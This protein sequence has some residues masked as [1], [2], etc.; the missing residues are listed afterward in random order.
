MR[1]IAGACAVLVVCAAL[2]M[3]GGCNS[4]SSGFDSGDITITGHSSTL[5]GSSLNWS[6]TLSSISSDAANV[7][8]QIK[9]RAVGSTTFFYSSP[10]HAEKLGANETK[11]FTYTETGISVPAGTTSVEAEFSFSAVPS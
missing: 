6:V 8:V 3:L 7:D 4:S 5:N 1:K 2:A 10:T 11:T 9:L